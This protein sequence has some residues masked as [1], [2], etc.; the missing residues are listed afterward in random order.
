MHTPHVRSG[1]RYPMLRALAIIYVI[2]AALAAVATVI[3]LFY[4]LFAGDGSF[5]DRVIQA[6]AA[7]AGGFLMVVTMLAV[8][9]VLKLFIDVEH[10]TRMA[11]PGRIGVPASVASGAATTD[12]GRADGMPA[13]SNAGHVNR[14]DALDEETAEAALI[15]GH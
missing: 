15:R 6:A 12:V 1:G 5:G 9:E 8:A 7:I 13:G 10:N 2:G 4:L 14:I 11:V 3:G